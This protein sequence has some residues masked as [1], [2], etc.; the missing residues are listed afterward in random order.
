MYQ[1]GSEKQP[2]N[3]C[4]IFYFHCDCVTPFLE[5]IS[6]GLEKNTTT[7]QSTGRTRGGRVGGNKQI[8]LEVVGCFRRREEGAIETLA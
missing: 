5:V 6:P 4:A 7:I 1:T 8:S 2:H 3:L